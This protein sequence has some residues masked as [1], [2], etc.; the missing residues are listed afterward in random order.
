VLV[1]VAYF[2]TV[3]SSSSR[4]SSLAE[5]GS[6]RGLFGDSGLVR[7]PTDVTT[8]KSDIERFDMRV[9]LA[10]DL[11]G[12]VERTGSGCMPRCTHEDL[13]S[14]T[15]GTMGHQVFLVLVEFDIRL[16]T[17][18]FEDVPAGVSRY[19]RWFDVVLNAEF[20]QRTVGAHL[21]DLCV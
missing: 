2:L 9:V 10:N 3:S 18:A 4:F 20:D 21:L 8:G 6:G 12:V 15:S 17:E 16:L 5:A 11:F 13:A 14:T 7:Q 19:R 1:T